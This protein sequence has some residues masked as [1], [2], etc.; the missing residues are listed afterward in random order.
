MSVV[1]GDTGWMVVSHVELPVSGDTGWM[2]VSPVELPVS[3]DTGWM[4]VSPVELPVSW[5]TGWMV[6][7]LRY[8]RS[9]DSLL[10]NLGCREL[11]AGAYLD[12]SALGWTIRNPGGGELTGGAEGRAPWEQLG[13][14]SP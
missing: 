12:G 2:V 11:L 13:E 3:R 7:C 1:S 10:L 5:D 14:K 6:D 9:L 4:V 8:L